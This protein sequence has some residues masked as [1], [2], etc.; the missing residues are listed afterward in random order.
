V[1]WIE[2]WFGMN[3]DGGDGSLER[4]IVGVVGLAV[5]GGLVLFI[6]AWRRRLSSGLA[7]VQAA[8]ARKA[9]RVHR[10]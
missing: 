6:P 1:D 5:A 9:G 4:L 8:L 7:R 2:Q 3:P 10:P